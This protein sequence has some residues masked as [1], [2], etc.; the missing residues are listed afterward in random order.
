MK[1]YV[2]VVGASVADEDL[3]NTARD[4]G[5]LL[6]EA[7]AVLLTGGFGGVMEASCRGAKESGGITV[8]ILPSEKKS[9]A[10]EYVDIA[11]PTGMGEMRN[12]LIVRAADA[13]I[14]VGG[15]FGTLSEIAFALR[16]DKPVVGLGTWELVKSG[17]AVKAFPTTTSPSEA[18]EL[19]LQ[20]ASRTRGT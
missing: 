11:I 14:A 5:R 4:V 13:L 6:G 18:V 12:A 3:S 9:D 8:A 17:E 19:A 15:E 16:T 2:A 1:T 7:G 10:N 20:A